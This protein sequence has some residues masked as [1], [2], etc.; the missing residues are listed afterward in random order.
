MGFKLYKNKN[1]KR[2]ILFN[3]LF[4]IVLLCAYIYGTIYYEPKSYKAPILLADS[5]YEADNSELID[6]NS[7]LISTLQMRESLEVNSISSQNDVINQLRGI[8]IAIIGILLTYV[9]SK[10]DKIFPYL[11]ILVLIGLFYGLEIHLADLSTLSKNSKLITAQELHTLVNQKS[12]ENIWYNLNY[13][14]RDSIFPKIHDARYPRKVLAIFRPDLVE[15][16]LFILPFLFVYSR[17]NY[18][19]YKK[20][21]SL[22]SKE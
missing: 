8:Y 20:Y 17:F 10:E 19:Y 3:I 2:F 16:V 6:H 7:K 5:S 9:I 21:L 11:V 22:K 14:E 15:I 12:S 4:F 1:K 13:S 18:K